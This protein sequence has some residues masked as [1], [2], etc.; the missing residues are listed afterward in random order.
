MIP[1]IVVVVVPTGV[2]RGEQVDINVSITN[3]TTTIKVMNPRTAGRRSMG[4]RCSPHPESKVS[5]YT[6]PIVALAARGGRESLVEVG[7]VFDVVG[8]FGFE[9]ADP[10]HEVTHHANDRREESCHDVHEPDAAS[11]ASSDH[12][13]DR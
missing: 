3:E 1:P 9:I 10:R 13:S 12:R 8:Q 7:R 4:G 5:S 2:V 6:F 11:G